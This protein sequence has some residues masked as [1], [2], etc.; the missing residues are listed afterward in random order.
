MY[1]FSGFLGLIEI[2]V[3]SRGIDF[4]PDAHNYLYEI[5]G[6]LPA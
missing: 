3:V 2:Y 5:T 1:V 6:E 4:T